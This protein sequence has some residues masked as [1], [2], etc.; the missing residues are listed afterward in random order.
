[1][2]MTEADYLLQLQELL[3]PGPAWPK[4]DGASI[5]R[6]LGALAAEFSR[7]DALALQVVDEGDPRETAALLP[8]WERVA[9][10]PDPL[11][12][13][14]GQSQ[15]VLER[16]AALVGRLTMLGGQ[17]AAY[18]VSVAA[19]LGYAVTV[20]EFRPQTTE[21]NTEYAVQDEQ[22][23]FI[24]Q[25]NAALNTIRDLTTESDTEMATAVW[26]NALLEATIKRYKPAHTLVLFA[27]S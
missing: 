9:G 26:G 12:M 19:A 5:T 20:T 1:M 6:T 18:F 3:P 22:Y 24:W 10:L 15:S 23:H 4:D 11:V 17:S 14:A 13:A 25:I 21:D 27:Y 2:V 16:R 7:V 8:D